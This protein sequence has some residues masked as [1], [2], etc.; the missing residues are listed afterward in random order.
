MSVNLLTLAQVGAKTSLSRAQIYRLI[1][2]NRFPPSIKLG[3]RR[4]A[5]IESE[6]SEWIEAKITALLGEVLMLTPN[7]DAAAAFLSLIGHQ[8]D[9]VAFKSKQDNR[10]TNTAD[11]DAL[12]QWA[13]K[14]PDGYNAYWHVNE[15]KKFKGG[16]ALKDQ[17]RSVRY[18]H[19]DI[20]PADGE[21][22]E[23][24]LQRTRRALEEP[25]QRRASADHDHH[26]RSRSPRLLA[27]A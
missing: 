24:A 25:P 18:V 6:V 12:R 27:A 2:A 11:P 13:T 10:Y 7:N 5:W 26:V 15:F 1:E 8:L 4:K 16:K 9:C 22:A 3:D 23:A 19:V 21:D 17:L 20:D 14:L